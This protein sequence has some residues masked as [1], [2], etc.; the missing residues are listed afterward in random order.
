MHE[1]ALTHQFQNGHT[2]NSP[3]V[4][5]DLQFAADLLK[6][7]EQ[8]NTDINPRNMA[9]DQSLQVQMGV[10]T[11]L[12]KYFSL[13]N[14]LQHSVEKARSPSVVHHILFD[15]QYMKKPYQKKLT[16][17]KSQLKLSTLENSWNTHVGHML[18]QSIPHYDS[19]TDP[20]V[21]TTPRKAQII[22]QTRNIEPHLQHL[23]DARVALTVKETNDFNEQKQLIQ[24]RA[25]DREG[26]VNNTPRIKK[27]NVSY[28]NG[29]NT[30]PPTSGRPFSQQ[31]TWNEQAD[32]QNVQRR[33]IGEDEIDWFDVTNTWPEDATHLNEQLKQLG[34]L[35]DTNEIPFDAS[36]SSTLPYEQSISPEPITI[37]DLSTPAGTPAKYESST[38]HMFMSSNGMKSNDQ[39]TLAENILQQFHTLLLFPPFDRTRIPGATPQLQLEEMKS[40]IVELAQ[41]RE[42]IIDVL[43]HIQ[44]REQCVLS[45]NESTSAS[46]T[47]VNISLLAEEDVQ[48]LASIARWSSYFNW[49]PSNQF[50]YKGEDY[51]EKIMYEKKMVTSFT[52]RALATLEKQQSQL[53]PPPIQPFNRSRHAFEEEYSVA[54]LQF[55]TQPE[56]L[57]RAAADIVKQSV[58]RDAIAYRKK[59][60]LPIP[61]YN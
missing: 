52:K 2:D 7:I 55:G 48:C 28:N 37:N 27:T 18:E 24:Q 1:H 54:A 16:H 26:K 57:A 42:S 3:P 6:H 46:D 45:I 4:Q 21:S 33:I 11:S 60:G 5:Q 35:G 58:Q 43:T 41:C 44:A 40:R 53:E 15:K 22:K 61:N 38:N 13:L 10:Q 31:S 19:I 8:S 56:Q 51:I 17:T 59:N 12:K 30:L 23:L 25:R 50:I 49:L 20:F 47:M 29:W 36:L 32:E 9:Q 14:K 34:L 39:L